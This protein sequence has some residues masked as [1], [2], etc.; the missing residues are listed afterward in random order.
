M[1]GEDGWAGGVGAESLPGMPADCYDLFPDR[2]VASETRRDTGGM[3]GW[4]LGRRDRNFQRRTPRTSVA[5]YW[6]GD[7]PWYTP[8]DAP[9]LS[10][11]FAIA[12]E[13]SITEA[14]VENS[15]TKI[16]PKGTTIITARGTVGRL[17]CLGSTDG[18]EPYL[19]RNSRCKWVS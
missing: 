4:G 1:R 2:L 18:Y 10:D 13:R 8:K 6:N 16:L 11:I 7:I 9:S 17:A 12:T 19:L 15:P 3:G 5:G 14:G